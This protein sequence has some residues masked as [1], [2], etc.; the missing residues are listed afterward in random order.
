MKS[1]LLLACT[2]LLLHVANAQKCQ[3][4]IQCFGNSRGEIINLGITSV[5]GERKPIPG[6]QGTF[7]CIPIPYEID[8]DLSKS[9]QLRE[10]CTKSFEKTGICTPYCWAGLYTP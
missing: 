2:V 10:F 9:P 6:E 1:L 5:P 8:D 4:Y 3:S 7:R